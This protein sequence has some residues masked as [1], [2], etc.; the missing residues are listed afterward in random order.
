MHK[1]GLK[2]TDILQL[3]KIY[4]EQLLSEV[5]FFLQYLFLVLH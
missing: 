4:E 1:A 2:R 5:Q 3:E